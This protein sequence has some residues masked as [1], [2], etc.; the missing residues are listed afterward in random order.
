MLLIIECKYKILEHS[1]TV[2]SIN[3]NELFE[4]TELIIGEEVEFSIPNGTVVSSFDSASAICIAWL[5]LEGERERESV[6]LHFC[7]SC[8]QI[9]IACQQG[10]AYAFA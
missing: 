7:P 10:L 3:K 5:L 8:Y 1:K 2:T 4:K 6:V 9:T